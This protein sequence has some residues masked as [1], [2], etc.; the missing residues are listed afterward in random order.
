MP[1]GQITGGWRANLAAP[2]AA[3]DIIALPVGLHAEHLSSGRSFVF[4]SVAIGTLITKQL[5]AGGRHHEFNDSYDDEVKAELPRVTI[6]VNCRWVSVPDEAVVCRCRNPRFAHP[7]KL[8]Y[9]RGV[10]LPW[11]YTEDVSILTLD[12]ALGMGG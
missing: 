11:N 12:H 8:D 3:A 9:V 5:A 7:P 4:F 2:D 10:Q 6:C 1:G